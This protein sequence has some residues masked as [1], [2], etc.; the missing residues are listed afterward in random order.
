MFQ[1]YS[2]VLMK[3]G[4]LAAT[5]G[6]YVI[7]LFFAVEAKAQAPHQGGG[8]D[9]VSISTTANLNVRAAA[10][11]GSRVIVT[12]PVGQNGVITAGPT[13]VGV[14][15]WFRVRFVRPDAPLEGWVASDFIRALSGAALPA[16]VAAGLSRRPGGLA[17]TAPALNGARAAATVPLNSTIITTATVNVR[18]LPG[19]GQSIVGTVFP[20]QVGLVKSYPHP[21]G[22]FDWYLISFADG[23]E[24]WAAIDRAI[25]IVIPPAATPPPASNQPLGE[26]AAGAAPPPLTGGRAGGWRAGENSVRV[27]ITGDQFGAAR[28]RDALSGEARAFEL[29]GR[30]P[31]NFL[32]N[33]MRTLGVNDLNR[34]APP[35]IVVDVR[36][37]GASYHCSISTTIEENRPGGAADARL[38]SPPL[39]DWV[40]RG[41]ACA[42]SD[43]RQFVFK[44]DVNRF[45]DLRAWRHQP[46][47]AESDGGGQ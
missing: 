21:N 26:R 10:G 9:G 18:T 25:A 42:P 23:T 37:S 32:N 16:N 41:G 15:T 11:L 35:T 12:M 40:W 34:I 33:L 29:E 1:S 27:L 7:F 6:F 39:G 13:R 24:G 43:S 30:A 45:L 3:R 31:A 4:L 5:V 22:G 20:G 44:L 38:A 14:Y 36:R 46:P 17:A 47:G 19:P 8:F 2:S 28:A